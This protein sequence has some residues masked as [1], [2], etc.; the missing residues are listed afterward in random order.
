MRRATAIF[1]LFTVKGIAAC[2]A[3]TEQK[4]NG[5]QQSNTAKDGSNHKKV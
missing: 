1:A 2:A 4:G 3:A 5:E